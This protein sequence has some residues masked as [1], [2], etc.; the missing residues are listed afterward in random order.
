MNIIELLNFELV[1]V[2]YYAMMFYL[3]VVILFKYFII[4][5][6]ISVIE[7]ILFIGASKLFIFGVFGYGV[8]WL[9]TIL[10]LAS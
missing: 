8:E 7:V 9:L 4:E 2:R 1:I 3:A 5:D 6:F 10:I